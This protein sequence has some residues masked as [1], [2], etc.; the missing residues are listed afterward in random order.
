M[1]STRR[2]TSQLHNDTHPLDRYH[3]PSRLNIGIQSQSQL[4]LTRTRHS[5]HNHGSYRAATLRIS[6]YLLHNPSPVVYY[7]DQ[8]GQFTVRPHNHPSLHQA[9]LHCVPFQP[10]DPVSPGIPHAQHIPDTIETH[11]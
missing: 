9:K 6:A 10:H 8:P 1:G 7:P 3:C 2:D 11:V 5:N 4:C